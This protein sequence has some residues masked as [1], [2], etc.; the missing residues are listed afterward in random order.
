[1]LCTNT[2]PGKKRRLSVLGDGGDILPLPHGRVVAGGQGRVDDVCQRGHQLHRHLLPQ[3][4]R[5]IDG[6]G[7]LFFQSF[8]WAV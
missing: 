8:G 1:M 5:D 2:Y 3:P 4:G 6:Q 7:A